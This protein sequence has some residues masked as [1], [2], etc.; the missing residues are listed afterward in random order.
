VGENGLYIGNVK[1][2]A[3]S[4]IYKVCMNYYFVSEDQIPDLSAVRWSGSG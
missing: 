3:R 1:I 4:E 2:M